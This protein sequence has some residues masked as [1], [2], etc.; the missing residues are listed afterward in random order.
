MKEES[1]NYW[2]QIERLDRLIRASELKA[3]LIISFHSLLVGV[4]FDRLDSL[5]QIFQDSISFIV[6]VCLWLLFVGISIYYAINCFIP[7]MELKYD[8]N[9]FFFS[10]AVRKYGDIHQFSKTYCKI[11]NNEKLL[12]DQLSQQVYIGSK[13]IDHKFKSVQKS[14]KYLAYSFIYVVLLLVLWLTML[15]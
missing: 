7:R 15:F 10:D 1:Y 3:G 13:I 8:N 14:V 11:C 5:Q 4:F 6:L 12:Y 9:V 2:M